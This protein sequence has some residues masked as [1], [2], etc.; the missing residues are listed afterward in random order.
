MKKIFDWIAGPL[1]VA[2]GGLLLFAESRRPLRKATSN[3]LKRVAT[4]TGLA[5]VTAIAIRLL[6]LPVVSR[7]SRIAQKRRFGLLNLV[8]MPRALR[9]AAEMLLLD[10]T[11]Y[12][13]HRF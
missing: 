13:W 10:Y 4:N 5:G 3:K 12:W 9:F 7:V 2:L 8:P 6:F 11:F 1:A